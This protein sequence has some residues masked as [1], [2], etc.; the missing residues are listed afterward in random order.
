MVR[1][2]GNYVVPMGENDNLL[3]EKLG[4][5][6]RRFGVFGFSFLDQNSDKVQGALI[7]GVEPTFDTIADGSYAVSR[8]LYFYVKKH[9]IAGCVIVEKIQRA[10]KLLSNDSASL[11]VSNEVVPVRLGIVQ[12]WVDKRYRRQGIAKS[13]I[14]SARTHTIYG[15]KVRKSECAMTQPTRDGRAFGER[16][17]GAGN[18]LVY[19]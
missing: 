9:V 14:D 3:I 5:D 10:H 19:E 1:T 11:R 13:L 4:K 8:P 6:E 18:L 17:F 15:S 7:D 2:D 16:Y 12:L